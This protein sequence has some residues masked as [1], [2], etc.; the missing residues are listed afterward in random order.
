VY[1]G[2][3]DEPDWRGLRPQVRAYLDYVLARIDEAV[4]QRDE[5]AG[6]KS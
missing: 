6:E 5:A 4:S 2:E 3:A 1:R